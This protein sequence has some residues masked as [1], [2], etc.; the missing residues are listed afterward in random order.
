VSEYQTQSDS[1]ES[2]EVE[3]KRAEVEKPTAPPKKPSDLAVFWTYFRRLGPAGPLAV[4]SFSLP[5]LGGFALLGFMPLYGD[6]LEAQG[7][8]GMFFYC[9]V[10]AVCSGLAILPT[11]A[12]AVVGGFVFGNIFGSIA[13][14]TG[15]VG[16]ALIGYTVGRRASGNRVMEIIAEKPK[17]QRIYETLVHRGKLRALGIITLLRVPPNSPFAITNLVMSGTK[18][19]LPIFIVGTLVGMAP[20]T[21]VAVY[22]GNELDTI[23][24]SDKQRL[25]MFVLL[26]LGAIIVLSILGTLANKAVEKLTKK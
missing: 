1:V 7:A 26:V 3:A 20:R 18:I 10:F 6:W 2:A 19:Q 8:L 5:A 15:Y 14:I 12:Q 4:L 24:F 13:A 21:I 17:W 11:Y 9:L 22:A 16:G 23:D 25:F